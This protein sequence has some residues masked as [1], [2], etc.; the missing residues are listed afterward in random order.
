[1]SVASIGQAMSRVDGRLKVTGQATYAAE[2]DPP[3]LAHAVIVTSTVAK[4]R[5]TSLETSSPHARPAF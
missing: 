1:M 5:I 2:F 4:G 3:N